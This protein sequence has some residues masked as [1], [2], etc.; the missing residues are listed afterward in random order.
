MPLFR[1]SEKPEFPPAV[2]ARPDG[3]LCIGGDLSPQRLVT[4]YKQGIFPWFSHRE[5]ILWW[6]PDPRMVLFP[7]NIHIS[8]SLKKQ[9]KKKP[10]EIRIN[11]D[12]PQVI[13][14]C[15]GPRGKKGEGTWIVQEM[16]EA[17][18]ELNKLGYAHSVEVWNEG[19]LKG[20]LYGL[21]IGRIF[22]GESMFSG[23]KDASKIA[24]T[25]LSGYLADHQFDLIDCQV[26][27]EHLRSMGAEEI[28]RARFLEIINSSLNKKTEE[29]LWEKG[30]ELNY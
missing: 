30:R 23:K 5:P 17:Y 19:V 4:A 20:G 14:A 28:P 7:E 13:K 26:S 10:F 16:I 2:F 21:C 25:A 3:L 22:F 9:M 24:L 6:S 11:T 12:F 1:L 27:S 18:V 29:D 8:R 15:A